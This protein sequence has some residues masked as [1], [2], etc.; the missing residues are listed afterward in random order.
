MDKVAGNMKVV[1][2][3]ERGG[4]YGQGCREYQGSRQ[5]VLVMVVVVERINRQVGSVA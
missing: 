5:W 4:G 2:I 3:K 1:R